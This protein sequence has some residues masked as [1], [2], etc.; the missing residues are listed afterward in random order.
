[1]VWLWCQVHEEDII[2]WKKI[3]KITSEI[4]GYASWCNGIFL[5]A[6]N[7]TF[8]PNLL[9]GSPNFH[10]RVSGGEKGGKIPLLKSLLHKQNTI[11][12]CHPFYYIRKVLLDKTIVTLCWIQLNS[13][14]T[15]QH[16]GTSPPPTTTLPNWL[17]EGREVQ[18]N[19][20]NNVQAQEGGCWRDRTD[21][22]IVITWQ[23]NSTHCFQV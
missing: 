6:C 21:R 12:A 5:S 17:G 18:E 13:C 10:C 20:Q 8:P 16:N 7:S 14:T 11:T 4:K 23:W 3:L 19:P 15:T 1:M 22:T 2:L 9:E